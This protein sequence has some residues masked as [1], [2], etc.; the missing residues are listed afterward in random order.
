[1]AYCV[2]DTTPDFMSLGSNHFTSSSFL[3]VK[4]LDFWNLFKLLPPTPHSKGSSIV[5][6]YLFFSSFSLK[7]RNKYSLISRK[8]WKY[9]FSDKV[10]SRGGSKVVFSLSSASVIAP[11]SSEIMSAII[12]LYLGCRW[13]GGLVMGKA[14]WWLLSLHVGLRLN[15]SVCLIVHVRV[16]A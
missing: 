3:P 2:P 12:H 9:N 14:L 16:C 4:F 7:A 11:P 5:W 13:E 8:E 1:M 6:K 15:D 10:H